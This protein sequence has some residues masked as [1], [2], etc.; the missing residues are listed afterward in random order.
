MLKVDLK[1]LHRYFDCCFVRSWF[2]FALCFGTVLQYYCSV[3]RV[4]SII[5]LYMCSTK[6]IKYG[7]RAQEGTRTTGITQGT[8]PQ[9]PQGREQRCNEHRPTALRSKSTVPEPH[10]ARAP[11]LVYVQYCEYKYKQTSRRVTD[12]QIFLRT[13]NR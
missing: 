12:K 5:L 7:P 13:A 9:A 2:V 3:V 4:Q 8:H 10:I 1:I 11:V 6:Q